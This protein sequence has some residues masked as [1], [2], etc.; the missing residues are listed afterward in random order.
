MKSIRRRSF[1]VGRV[2]VG[3]G[4]LVFICGPCV[5][6]SRDLVMR[7]ADKLKEVSEQLGIQLIFKSSYDKANRTSIKSF[8]GPGPEE[9][10][11]ILEGVKREF[12][13]PVLSDVHCREHVKPASEV[14][15]VI[16]IPAFL[17]R[18]TDIIVESARTGKPLNIKKG[19]FMSPHDAIHAAWKAESVGNDK[20]M[21]T[22]R[23][24]FFGY[25]D[26]V[27][28]MRSLIVMG[29]SGFPVFFDATHSVQKPSTNSG[30]SGGN[31]EFVPYLARSA[32]A[33]GIDGFYFEVHPEPERALSD[34]AT[35]I[36]FE[37]LKSTI[38]DILAIERALR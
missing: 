22:E 5:I 37:T 36:D 15:D 3:A 11:K 35:S 14:L 9:G 24:T 34:S 1:K 33:I 6:E 38:K 4:K 30:T 27:V 20:V 10:L 29:V 25:G 12:D 32:A 13:L 17:S 16:Q 19:Q 7:V 28:D 21:L 23:G 31:R 8:R 26:F 2:E 18:Q